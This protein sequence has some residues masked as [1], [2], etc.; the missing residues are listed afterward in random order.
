[1]FDDGQFNT[2]ESYFST[3]SVTENTGSRTWTIPESSRHH[4]PEDARVYSSGFYIVSNDDSGHPIVYSDQVRFVNVEGLITG[5]YLYI[6]SLST[7]SSG[8]TPL[9]ASCTVTK[10]WYEESRG[11]SLGYVLSGSRNMYPDDGI[12]G[13]YWYVYDGT[14][15]NTNYSRGDYIGRVSGNSTSQYPTNG[16]HSDGYWYER[17]V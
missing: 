8:N 2:I 13:S 4:Y 12:Y 7:I 3:G 15:E 14:V 10:T 5:K 6:S 1:M 16:R 17:I 11:S 9:Y